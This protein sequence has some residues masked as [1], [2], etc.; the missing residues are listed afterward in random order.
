MQLHFSYDGP[1]C[2]IIHWSNIPL[3]F[4]KKLKREYKNQLHSSKDFTVMYSANVAP[5]YSGECCLTD[6]RLKWIHYHGTAGPN[7]TWRWMPLGPIG[8]TSNEHV[9]HSSCMEFWSVFIRRFSVLRGNIMC[10]IYV[11]QISYSVYSMVITLCHKYFLVSISVKI[12]FV[13]F[14]LIY[15]LVFEKLWRNKLQFHRMM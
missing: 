6:S 14:L 3:V 1:S 9:K 2:I 15:L 10:L 13:E 5:Q 7:S 8:P 11:F 12:F 4:R